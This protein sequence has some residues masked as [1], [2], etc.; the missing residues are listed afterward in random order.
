M[1][2]ACHELDAHGLLQGGSAVYQEYVTSF[3][4]EVELV[5]KCDK[6]KDQIAILDQLVTFFTLTISSSATSSNLAQLQ[7]AALDKKKELQEMVIRKF[8]GSIAYFHTY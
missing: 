5:D 6:L 4:R 3:R 7:K 1:E 2:D 8:S